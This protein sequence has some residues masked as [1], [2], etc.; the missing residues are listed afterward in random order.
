[1]VIFLHQYL[2]KF[3]QIVP[4]A[5]PCK[6]IRILV[7]CFVFSFWC[8]IHLWFCLMGGLQAKLM[9]SQR[10]PSR[11]KMADMCYYGNVMTTTRWWLCITI[12]HLQQYSHRLNLLFFLLSSK[13]SD[14]DTV[15]NDGR[16]VTDHLPSPTFLW[17]IHKQL[18]NKQI[19]GKPNSFLH[20]KV[21]SVTMKVQFYHLLVGLKRT[22][23]ISVTIASVLRF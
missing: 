20:Q 14:Q 3:V 11:H 6:C 22:M 7:L 10:T 16:S 19:N 9:T 23:E 18:R 1:M 12:L 17:E 2:E 13:H 8:R 21:F 15:I 4:Q 5:S